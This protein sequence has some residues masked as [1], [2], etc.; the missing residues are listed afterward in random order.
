MLNGS[1]K[2]TH[3]R[4]AGAGIGIHPGAAR[5][6]LALAQVA[7]QLPTYAR[8]RTCLPPPQAFQ[9]ARRRARACPGGHLPAL[10]TPQ[11]FSRAGLNP[12]APRKGLSRGT[13]FPP[14]RPAVPLDTCPPPLSF[15]P[16]PCPPSLLTAGP[17]TPRSP[18]GAAPGVGTWAREK[19]ASSAF[20]FSQEFL[21]PAPD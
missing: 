2:I 19:A 1:S 3:H 8:T 13:P 18:Q 5:D 9:R 21:S 10:G 20:G 11:R 17:P 12:S 14:R 16:L 15:H 6:C 4:D 7:H